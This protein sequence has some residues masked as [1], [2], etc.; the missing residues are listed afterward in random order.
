MGFLSKLFSR[1]SRFPGVKENPDG[2][3]DFTLT[4]E[5]A[6]EADRALLMF[7]DVLVHP[8]AADQI[9][10]GTIAVALC[11]YALDLVADSYADAK[12]TDDNA[13]WAQVNDA[14]IKAVAAS[15]KAYSLSPL[16]IFLYHRAS[17]Y[18]MLNMSDKARPLF[19][20]FL[21]KQADFHTD[22]ITGV[23]IDLLG[24]DIQ[25]AIERANGEVE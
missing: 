23:L 19:S 1:G 5:E 15:W 22:Q 10:N 13:K 12:D 18:Q 24:S 25:K 17:F 3:I 21:K 14:S 8:D 11:R 20:A 2:T 7:K 16:P 6:R 9:R 4:D